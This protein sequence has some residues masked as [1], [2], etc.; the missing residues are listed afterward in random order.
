M[1]TVQTV[2]IVEIEVFHTPYTSDKEEIEAEV[3]R[4]YKGVKLVSALKLS[5]RPSCP[6]FC[7][8]R[9]IAT[10]EGVN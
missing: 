2:Q 9:Y 10:L 8:T 4:D 3:E 6:G 7:F 5:S 1:Q